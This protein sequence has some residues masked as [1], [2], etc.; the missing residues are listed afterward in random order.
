MNV[1]LTRTKA[2][3]LGCS[4]ALVSCLATSAAR[5]QVTPRCAF[6]LAET[7]G[8]WE[9]TERWELQP[10]ELDILQAGDHWRRVYQH[11]Q[12]K[13]VVVVT[14][15]AGPG[16][17]LAS[18]LPETC[19]ARTEFRAHSEPVVWNMPDQ[20]DQFRCQTL[21]PREVDQPALTIAYAWHDGS[22]WRAPQYPRFQL[23]GHPTLQRLLVSMRH[24]GGMTAEAQRVIRQVVGLTVDAAESVDAVPE[25]SVD[26]SPPRVTQRSTPAPSSN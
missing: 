20:P 18:H 10:G 14:L 25:R 1:K 17:P 22:H 8:Q 3:V 6:E 16:G 23:A 2:A 11:R 15:I 19:Y 26:S 5:T 21:Q 24:P 12:T 9:L 4:L 13:Q 7:L